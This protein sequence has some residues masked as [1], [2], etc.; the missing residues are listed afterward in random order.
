MKIQKIDKRQVEQFQTDLIKK[1]KIGKSEGGIKQDTCNQI[2]DLLRRVLNGA[3]NDEIILVNPAQKVS[4]IK[5]TG[6]KATETYHRAL[7]KE[8]QKLFMDELKESNN[9]YY[10]FIA[11]MLSTGMREGEVASLKW[12]DVDYD[13]NIIHVH[14]TITLSRGGKLMIGDTAKT[15]AGT[16][17]IPLTK[18]ARQLLSNQRNKNKILNFSEDTIFKTRRG[19][20]I[21]GE[22]INSAIA[23]V[24]KR[25]ERKGK[26]IEHFTSHA[27]RDTYATRCVEGKMD[28]KTLQVLMGH[29]KFNLTMSLYAHVMEDTKQAEMEKVN[30]VI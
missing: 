27:L 21:Y 19:G 20:K 11:F 28:I 5:L 7:T 1:T 16:R 30:I 8:E 26:P 15:P 3:V 24:L 10:D 2:F 9:Y 13:K 25:L 22:N 14:T 18:N 4:S 23:T 29:E 12:S 17:D 6:K